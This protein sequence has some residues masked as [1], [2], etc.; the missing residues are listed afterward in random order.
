[1]ENARRN[2]WMDGYAEHAYIL[3]V[4]AY[5]VWYFGMYIIVYGVY[6]YILYVCRAYSQTALFRPKMNQ[7]APKH[8]IEAINMYV[9][10]RVCVG[11]PHAYVHE[12]VSWPCFVHL[13]ELG[14]FSIP[15]TW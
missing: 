3:Y 9:C 13:A 7:N 6:V 15:C 8:L 11:E 1:M 2:G 4:S 10:V 12:C 5:F 14:L